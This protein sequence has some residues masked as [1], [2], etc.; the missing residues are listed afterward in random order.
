MPSLRRPPYKITEYLAIGSCHGAGG[1]TLASLVGAGFKH[2]IDL[3]A[4]N[5]EKSLSR[6]VGLSYHPIKA[7]DE[8]GMRAWKNKVQKAVD[9]I[10]HA[11]QAREKVYLHCTYGRGR[12]AT[13]AMAYLVSKNKSVE[14]AIK[15][16]KARGRLV[17]CEGNP[18]SKYEKIL[19]FYYSGERSRHAAKKR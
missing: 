16:V 2:V 19:Q 14:E 6:K 11:T 5:S 9:V 3:N 18:V 17:W 13:I 15:Y 7:I 1:P 10:E 8:Y 12:S 4:D